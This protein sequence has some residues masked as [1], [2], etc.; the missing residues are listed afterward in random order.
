MRLRGL[1]NA[2]G[3]L[4]RSRRKNAEG[5]RVFNFITRGG[6]PRLVGNVLLEAHLAGR[7][8]SVVGFENHAG[9]TYLEDPRLEAFGRVVKVTATTARTA[10]KASNTKT[11]SAPT[12]TAHYCPKTRL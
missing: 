2:G 4:H 5:I 8:T 7:N 6:E 10:V 3:R 9:R 12:C 11:S 1:P